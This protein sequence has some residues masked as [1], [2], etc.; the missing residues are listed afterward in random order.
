M[1]RKIY[2]DFEKI[3]K[4][5]R[6]TEKKAKKII[7]NKIGEIRRYF[8][9]SGFKKA[10]IGTS[11][12]IDSSLSATLT[13]KALGP[14]NVYFVRMPYF[15]ISS[16]EGLILAE[17]LAKNLKL[18]KKNLITIPINKPVD[19]SWKALKKFKGGNLKIRKGNLMA[20][21]RMKILFDL[22]SAK[23][24]IVVGSEDRSEERLGYFTIGGDRVSGIETINN[25]FKTQVFQVASFFK[26]I[27]D[28]ILKR[29]P[30]P[31]LWKGQTDEGEIG[32]SYLEI[33]TILSAIEDL[34]IPKK[35]IGKKFKI[36]KSKI[37]LILKKYQKA[38]GKRF[39]PYILRV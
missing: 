8:K 23:K 3:P 38:K 1:S 15:G 35:E 33:D 19:Q 30:S 27:P 32:A 10:V 24:A 4:H 28:E 37:D 11:G 22:A 36:K 5:L 6:M 39:L 14:K 25:L 20:R 21:E 9:K 13:V 12:G 29:T 34:K 17:K 31:E 16:K 7:L 18:P 2:F 26:E